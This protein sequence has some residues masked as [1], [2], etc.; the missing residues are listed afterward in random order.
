MKPN[1]QLIYYITKSI[2]LTSFEINQQKGC[3]EKTSKSFAYFVICGACTQVLSLWAFFYLYYSLQANYITE[4]VRLFVFKCEIVTIHVKS[5]MSSSF[6]LWYHNDVIKLINEIISLKNILTKVYPHED[7]FDDIFTRLFTIRC[8]LLMVQTSISLSSFLFFEY[9]MN[10]LGVNLGWTIFTFNHVSNLILPSMFFY[11]GLIVNSRFLRIVNGS[12][13]S[14][15]R[16]GKIS[17]KTAF[18]LDQF[19]IF[20]EKSG[21]IA[22]R[23]F[24]IFGHQILLTLISSSG[25]ALSSVSVSGISV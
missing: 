8:V 5:L 2:G 23:V 7:F 11:A 18:Q 16:D 24:H 1:L 17:D 15:T 12:L 25:F 21:M 22:D 3:V 9:T 20:F 13:E 10:E 6:N 4:T 19:G 14:M